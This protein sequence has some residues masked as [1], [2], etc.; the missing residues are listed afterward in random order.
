MRFAESNNQEKSLL[1]T[2][3]SRR[4]VL[5]LGAATTSS[6]AL[7]S[8]AGGLLAPGEAEAAQTVP[9]PWK[10]AWAYKQALPIPAV[11]KPRTS[12]VGPQPQ[13]DAAL[14][15]DSPAFS[16]LTLKTEMFRNARTENYQRWNEFNNAN[17][18]LYEVMCSEMEWSF[19]P[20]DPVTG[21]PV[22]PPSKVWVFKDLND[23]AAFGLIRIKA[24]Y[25]KPV[26]MRMHNCLPE[27]NLGFGIPQM[28]THLHNAHNPP[29]S[30]GGP[31]RIYPSGY[32]Y[33]YWYPN[34]RA[35][36]ASTHKT[37]TAFKGP[38][39]VTRTCQG[40]YKETQSSLWFHDHRMDYTSQNV[41]A[42]MASF[43]SLFSDDINL[44][45]VKGG[46]P[47]VPASQRGLGLPAGNYD[48]P[49]VITDKRFDATS[50]QMVMDLTDFGGHI[51]DMTT[52]NFKI[53]PFL[54]VEAR[55][56]RFRFLNAGPSRF[57]EL[58]F[59]NNMSF[60]RIANDG[61]LLPKAQNLTS[62]RLGCAERADVIVDFSNYKP[63]TVLYLENIL[64][65]T[66]SQGVS[67]KT[68]G[69]TT[70]PTLANSTQIMKIIVGNKPAVA[71]TTATLVS[72]VG[73]ASLLPLPTIPTPTKTRSFSFGTSNG[74]WN[75]N[76]RL[77]D[78]SVISAYP[79]EGSTEEWTF[80]GGNGW[81]H[82]IH[83]H[84]DEFQLTKRNGKAISTTSGDDYS[85]KDVVRI[86]DGGVGTTNTSSVTL[87]M[88]FRD[89]YGDYP[90]HCH[91]VVHEDHAMMFRMKVV[92]K[93]DPNAGK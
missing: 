65:Q 76:G 90:I 40:D 3:V 81:S 57:L 18:D 55:R 2:A 82:P 61:N 62:V 64:E 72:L 4:D 11:L 22:V 66:S 5:K 33:D 54:N 89:W 71:D 80:T 25:G 29:E 79:I 88:Q 53:K 42:G 91:N 12:M 73:L 51:G 49:M 45:T 92:P 85:R 46:E 41:Y 1:D 34:V 30:D 56:Y 9:S 32:Y 36:F 17:A 47:G 7:A 70:D 31:L 10:S 50:G 15:G 27:K 83:T 13:Q 60:V 74:M 52:V 84:H 68:L 14:M 43:Y 63:G 58:T 26:I 69:R 21:V 93:T 16:P 67:G 6:V 8:V 59:S 19:Y 38:D 24:Q 78:P 20:N 77:F 44:D 39:G 86:G 23:P 48:I 87:R 35:G 28:S 75:V 37:G